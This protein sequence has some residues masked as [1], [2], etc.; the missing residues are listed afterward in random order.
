MCRKFI[1]DLPAT[2]NE[3]DKLLTRNKIFVERN[4]DVAVLSKADAI[5]F[6]ADNLVG[7]KFNII[8]AET[9]EILDISPSD[10]REIAGGCRDA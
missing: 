10:I 9:L 2:I 5:E 6:T 3:V 8:D 1:A 7:G 4:R